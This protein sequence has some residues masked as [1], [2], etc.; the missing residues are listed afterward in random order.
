MM[1]INI[2]LHLLRHS[3]VAGPGLGCFTYV[4]YILFVSLLQTRLSSETAS[5]SLV[6]DWSRIKA[7]FHLFSSPF[8]LSVSFLHL[9]IKGSVFLSV[10]LSHCLI[11]LSVSFS[12][13][14][15]LLL[16]L[17]IIIC[18]SFK[19]LCLNVKIMF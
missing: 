18:W 1:E 5:S 4:N 12:L 13:S 16:L 14:A 7:Q 6:R 8:F 17:S 11:Y 10:F 15:C 19:N 2:N 3:L 9:W